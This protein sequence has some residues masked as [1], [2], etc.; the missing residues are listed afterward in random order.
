MEDHQHLEE[1]STHVE[2]KSTATDGDTGSR[3]Y[4]IGEDFHD[5]E[6]DLLSS[7]VFLQPNANEMPPAQPDDGKKV[8]AVMRGRILE[9]KSF[10]FPCA[11]NRFLQELTV[12]VMKRSICIPH[13]HI[14]ERN[15]FVVLLVMQHLHVPLY[16]VVTREHTPG[17]NRSIVLFVMQRSRSPLLFA[18]MKGRIP[19][20]N[21]FVVLFVMQYSQIPLTCVVMKGRIL[22]RNPSVFLVPQIVSYKQ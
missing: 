4:E 2:A 1:C 8:C 19:E 15:R 14:P 17:R 18:H 16:F 21:R 12:E 5:R 13:L 7:E 11:T 9:R 20:T 3:S 22:E 6:K 10:L